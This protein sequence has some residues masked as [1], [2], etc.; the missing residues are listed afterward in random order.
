[1]VV[2]GGTAG[3]VLPAL[4]VIEAMQR[5]GV[6][7]SF[8]GTHS[9]L[10]Q[11]LLDGSDVTFYAISAGKLRRYVSWD[12]FFDL[13]RIVWGVVQAYF[14]IGKI[15]PAVVFSKGGFVSFPVAFA[16][17]LRRVPVV[18]HESD[19]TPGLAN[20]L[21]LPFIRSLCVSFPETNIRHTN[22][23]VIHTGT[24]VRQDIV[25]GQ[26][27]RGL[28]LLGLDKAK[29]LLI[30][31]GGSLGAQALN[32]AVRRALPQLLERFY[33]LHVCGSGKQESIT[34]PCYLQRE[35]VTHGW[36]DMLAAAEVV[37]SRAGANA[38]FEWLTIRKRNLLVPLPGNTSRGDQIENAAYAQAAG[39]SVVIRQEA[40]DTAAL[41]EG[42]ETLMN[43][44]ARFDV[45][46]QRFE[47]PD[48]TAAIVNELNRVVAKPRN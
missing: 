24:P 46:L 47:V 20:R 22:V 27:E 34:Q 39:Y 41:L 10:E 30:V 3:H 9:G 12:N 6:E 14:L 16:A 36:G 25:Q 48:A 42:L 33:V 15:R 28:Q 38:L 35:Y 7:V 32:A 5:Q 1:M 26:A 8:I 2:G 4:P 17:W 29:P 23:K 19:I 31:T 11:N 43:E 13:F 18:A 45:A 21:L 40:L 44:A 37:V